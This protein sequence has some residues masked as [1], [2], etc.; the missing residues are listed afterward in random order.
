MAAERELGGADDFGPVENVLGWQ[1]HGAY[2][3][4]QQQR[5]AKLAAM[6]MN[7]GTLFRNSGLL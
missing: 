5:Q 1:I 7:C 3:E 6:S 4:Q 2:T